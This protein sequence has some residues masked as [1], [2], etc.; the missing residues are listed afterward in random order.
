MYSAVA[1]A[2]SV[3]TSRRSGAILWHRDLS[4]VESGE[5]KAKATPLA[6]SYSA[7]GRTPE[8]LL[9]VDKLNAWRRSVWSG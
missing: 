9:D 8:S 1:S 2:W 6:C 3:L 7:S 5:R 4:A